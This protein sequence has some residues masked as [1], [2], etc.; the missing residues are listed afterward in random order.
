MVAPLYVSKY[1]LLNKQTKNLIAKA[2]TESIVQFMKC[3]AE[4]PKR[5][6]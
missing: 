4:F 1:M 6:H 2:T 3:C 5:H